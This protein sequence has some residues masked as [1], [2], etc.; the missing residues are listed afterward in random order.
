[1]KGVIPDCL[2][3]LVESKFGKDKWEDS[4]EAAG[5][6]RNTSFPVT[7]DV[8]DAD[9]IKV[10]ESV[11]KVLNITLQQAADAFGDFWVNDYAPKIYKSYYRQANSAKEMLLNMDNVHKTVTQKIPNAHPPRFA[12]NWENDKTLVMTYKSDRGLIDFLVG[13]IKGVGKYYKEDLK[14]V[15]LGNDKVQIIFE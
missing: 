1:M 8:P 15:K 5:L 10:V 2:S 12:Y 7:Q 11:C 3:K 13:L 9:V 4:L 6:P 14:V